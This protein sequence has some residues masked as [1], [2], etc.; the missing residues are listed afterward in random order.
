MKT[1]GNKIEIACQQFLSGDGSVFSIQWTVFPEQHATTLTPDFIMGEYLSYLRRVTLSFAR[2]VWT[3]NGL[4][5][6]F[7]STKIHLLTFAALAY[8]NTGGICSASFRICGGHFVQSD[9]CNR[10]RFSFMS[11]HVEGGVRVTVQ[12]TNYYP[13]LLGSS[14]P[15]IARKWL[16][17]LTQASVHKFLTTRFLAHLYR[18]LEGEGACFRVVKV[19]MPKGEDI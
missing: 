9:Q 14:T 7:L 5:F 12:L 10:G 17:R 4:E 16:Y 2:P 18:G 15:S 3:A 11:E 13:R 8:N 1:T 6:R 19:H